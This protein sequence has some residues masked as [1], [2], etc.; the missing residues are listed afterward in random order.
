MSAEGINV[1]SLFDGMSCGQIAL[2]RSGIKV[3]NYFASEIDKHAIKVTQS[4]YPQTIQLGD[5]TQIKSESLPKIDL[6]LAGSPCQGFSFSGKQ[7][8]FDDPRSRLFFEFVRL[9]NELNPTEFLLENVEMAKEHR[10]VIT[11]YVGVRP[12]TI[13]SALVSAQNRV[14]NYWTNIYSKRFGLFDDLECGIPQPIDRGVFIK[15]ILEENVS[16]KYNLSEKMLSYFKQRKANFNSGKVN[17]R[18]PNGK[19]SCLTASMAKMD[20]S[21]NYL[22][23]ASRG[24][25]ENPN[26]KWEQQMEMRLDGKTNCLT[27]CSKDNMVIQLNDSKESNGAQPYQQNRVYDIN[28]KSPALLAEMSS[29]THA[30]MDKA[31]CLHGFEHGTNGQFNKMLAKGGLL[32]RFTEI[33]CERLQGVPDNYTIAASSTQR[34]KMLGNGWQVDTIVHMLNYSTFAKNK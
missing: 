29:K 7:L 24:R 15:D 5:V 23:V 28:G 10:K 8:A 4:N 17:V 12:I 1:L 34:Y 33:E 22:C 2:E 27:S 11:Q 30:I 26:S 14:R 16:P 32:R 13:N 25:K 19:A 31:P 20:I 3:A 9:R 21:D 18:D 6:I